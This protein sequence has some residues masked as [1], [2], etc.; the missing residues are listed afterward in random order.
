MRPRV[1]TGAEEGTTRRRGGTRRARPMLATNVPRQPTQATTRLETPATTPRETRATT[2][3]ETRATTPR[4]T[5]ATTRS[6]T[7]VVT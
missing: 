5:R 4:E 2:P 1:T 6:E 7:P 3:R